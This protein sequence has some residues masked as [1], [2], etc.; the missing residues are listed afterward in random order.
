M[1]VSVGLQEA[2]INIATL[3]GKTQPPL[4]FLGL[5]SISGV[6]SYKI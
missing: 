1:A 6:I 3:R 2:R 5:L 4:K